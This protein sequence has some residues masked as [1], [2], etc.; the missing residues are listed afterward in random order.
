MKVDGMVI[1]KRLA[2][3]AILSALFASAAG[4]PS[5]FAIWTASALHARSGQLSQRMDSDKAA[6]ETLADF[7]NHRMMLAHREASGAAEVHEKMADILIVE[8]GD[9]TLVVGG[10]MVAARATA[11]GEVRGTAIDGGE[12][13]RLAAG[14][15]V[16]IPAGVP[17]RLL[18]DP[19]HRITYL[20]A[21]VESR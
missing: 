13:H 2:V 17:H 8:D 19:G 12:R 6:S 9:A 21:K 7:G 11:P 4:D 15:L 3:L 14:D 20:V 1:M 16:H 18:L 5:G 10:E